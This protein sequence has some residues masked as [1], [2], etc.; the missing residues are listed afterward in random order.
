[1]D[2]E[3]DY[4]VLEGAGRR[5]GNVAQDAGAALSGVRIDGV[6][7]AVPGGTAG[8]V[9]DRLDEAWRGN[10]AE[11]NDALGSYATAL[12]TT[13]SYYRSMEQSATDAVRGFFGGA[14]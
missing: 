1:M 5:A 3:A 2:Y 11:L 10:A 9:A 4:A 7:A 8:A 14:Q 12:A 6:G 13:A